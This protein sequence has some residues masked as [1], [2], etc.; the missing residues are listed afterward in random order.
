MHRIE[1]RRRIRQR[2][3]RNCNVFR[4]EASKN[5]SCQKEH[6]SR[7]ILRGRR[8]HS[9]QLIRSKNLARSSSSKIRIYIFPLDSAIKKKTIEI[10]VRTIKKFDPILNF[11]RCPLLPVPGYRTATGRG[12][13]W[14]K[15]ASLTSYS[16][17][18]T[19]WKKERK[20]SSRSKKK[21][22]RKEK[23]FRDLLPCLPTTHHRVKLGRCRGG[24]RAA[25]N[26]AQ[27]SISSSWEEEEE[28][29]DDRARADRSRGTCQGCVQSFT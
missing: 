2:L 16:I 17:V 9:V 12:R 23:L 27:I 24:R 20:N 7:A 4:V 15:R 21:I 10:T 8:F 26:D 6:S 19:R 29:E 5:R 28:E 11:S 25:R 3:L 14:R 1:T 18:R 22:K 13:G